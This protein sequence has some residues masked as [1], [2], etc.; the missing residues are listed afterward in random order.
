MLFYLAVILKPLLPV[1]CDAWAHIFEE[2]EH[3][4]TVHAKYGS[5][6]AETAMAKAGGENDSSKNQNSSKTEES[7]LSHIFIEECMYDF[8]FNSAKIEHCI[9]QS[10]DLPEN[11]LSKQ[12]PPPKC[13]WII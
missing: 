10:S 4:A 2:A 8:S 5:N 13:M 6:H 3:I 12:A 9:L 7:S 11:V 1:V